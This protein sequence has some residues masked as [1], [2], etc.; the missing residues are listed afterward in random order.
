[1]NQKKATLFALCAVLLWSTVASAFKLSLR[2]LRPDPLLFWS[3]LVSTVVLGIALAA[4][5][6]LGTAFRATRREVLLSA[7]Q[8]L[9]NPFLYYVVLFRAYD[10]LPGQIAQPLNYTWALAIALLSVPMLKQRIRPASFFAL[11]VSLF[12]VMVISTRGDLRSLRVE[13]PLGVGLAVGSSL[14]WA[15]YWILNLRDRRAAAAKLFLGFCFGTA[16]TLLFCLATR[17]PLALPLP[18][19]LGAAYIG[20]FE[21]GLTFLLWLDALRLSRTTAAV[22]NLIFLSPFV[23]LFLLRAVV[24][25]PL[26]ASSFLGLVAIVAGIILQQRASGPEPKGKRGVAPAP[27]RLPD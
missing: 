9:L 14:I 19:A 26:H 21:M 5:R 15:L 11:L 20:L 12:G 6:R 24:G 22:S 7:L 18:G 27:G 13:E 16:F 25:E 1:M 17:A 8:G 3:A 4:Q 2:F 10:R 23:S